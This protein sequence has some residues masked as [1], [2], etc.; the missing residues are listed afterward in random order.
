M[1]YG[2]KMFS[3]IQPFGVVSDLEEEADHHITREM[4]YLGNI[5]K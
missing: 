1:D 5:R 2:G 3:N 4:K